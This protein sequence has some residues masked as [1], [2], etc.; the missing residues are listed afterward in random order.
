[1]YLER[2]APRASTTPKNRGVTRTDKQ[3]AAAAIRE[4]YEKSATYFRES[5]LVYETDP[6]YKTLPKEM[7]ER[8]TG[9]QRSM[10]AKAERMI[11]ECHRVEAGGDWGPDLG[12]LGL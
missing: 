4:Q 11:A 7:I 3:I 10:L 8:V 2:T 9:H 12:P 6:I 5:L 1:M